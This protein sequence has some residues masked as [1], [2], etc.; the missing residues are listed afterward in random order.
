MSR[1]FVHNVCRSRPDTIRILIAKTEGDLESFG[2]TIMFKDELS[3][4]DYYLRTYEDW[5]PKLIFHSD[6]PN[7]GLKVFNQFLAKVFDAY[8]AS[9]LRRRLRLKQLELRLLL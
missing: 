3:I 4:L 5:S 1:A 6:Q 9:S 7:D 8:G 2:T